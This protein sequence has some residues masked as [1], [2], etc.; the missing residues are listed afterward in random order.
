MEIWKNVLGYEGIYEVSSLGRV[1]SL[2]FGKERI[3]KPC[4]DS[5]GYLCFNLCKK[6]SRKS[7]KVH[8]FVAMAFLNHK[9]NKYK[10][11]VNHKNFNKT[12]NRVDNLELITQRQNT[13]LKHL[14]SSS[15]Y[16]GVYWSRKTNKWIAQIQ[17]NRKSK[18]LGAFKNEIDASNAYQNE[19]INISKVKI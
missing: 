5:T 14:K 18:Y 2:K 17:V 11:V 10:L 19:L 4:I 7:I 1:K 9:P 12:D 3:L 6:G 13:N 8:Q 15:Q 16:V